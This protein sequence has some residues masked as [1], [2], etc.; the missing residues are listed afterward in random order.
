[1]SNT[2]RLVKEQA[3]SIHPIYDGAQFQ[4]G[5]HFFA[6]DGEYL[7]S[8][9]QL[10]KGGN[11]RY[12]VGADEAPTKANAPAP[13]VDMEAL[14]AQIREEEAAKLR[15]ELAK[16][17]PAPAKPTAK[18]AKETASTGDK[19]KPAVS[20]GIDLAAWARDEILPKPAWFK[21][22]KAAEAFDPS[23]D[24]SNKETLTAG[25]VSLGVVTQAEVDAG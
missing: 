13:S 11:R 14:R 22:K 23:I 4:M 17:T 9:E 10:E 25:L 6:G 1:M 12:K 8:Q 24:T 21:V 2:P 5:E 20:N 15:A 3:A 16:D 18:P 7:F 19:S